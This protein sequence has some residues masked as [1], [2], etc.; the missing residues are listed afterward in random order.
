M[1]A[2]RIVLFAI[3]QVFALGAL[4]ALYRANRK[5]RFANSVNVAVKESAF[6]PTYFKIYD[7]S[8]KTVCDRLIN[9][10]PFDWYVWACRGELYIINPEG[11]ISCG[12]GSTPVIRITTRSLIETCLK[13]DYDSLILSYQRN[14]KQ[15]VIPY[16]ITDT[17][18]FTILSALNL[19][20][21]DL[22]RFDVGTETRTQPWV[23]LDQ[24]DRSLS[25]THRALTMSQ[26]ND[27]VGRA[28][29]TLSSSSRIRRLENRYREHVR[30]RKANVVAD[31][32]HYSDTDD[33]V[34]LIR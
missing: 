31:N 13:L 12:A 23:R 9:V 3:T 34:S 5:T 6:S 20:L 16:T 14:A 32:T 7:K 19:M 1:D 25:R 2:L 11:R 21:K 15:R 27:L 28:R 10:Q 8:S 17:K 18:R 4:F 30:R 26:L 33:A 24:V 22:I 29:E